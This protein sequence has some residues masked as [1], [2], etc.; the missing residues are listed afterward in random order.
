M[1]T[2]LIPTIM[3]MLF[4][5]SSGVAL[6]YA[7]ESYGW[8]TGAGTIGS[9]DEL[10]SFGGWAAVFKDG[11]VRGRWQHIDQGGQNIFQGKVDSIIVWDLNGPEVSEAVPNKA[12]LGGE[13]KFNGVPGYLFIVFVDVFDHYYSITIYKND[14]IVFEADDIL[15]AG[16]IQIHPSNKGHPPF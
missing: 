14:E 7:S 12:I 8:V 2:K 15:S 16:N 11:S 9:G 5:A 3:V 4:L 6:V 1:K 13:G 10:D